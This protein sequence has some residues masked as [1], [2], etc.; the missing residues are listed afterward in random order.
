MLVTIALPG[1]YGN[2]WLYAAC[3][4]KMERALT[5]SATLEEACALLTLQ[6]AGAKRM[7]SLAGLNVVL[8]LMVAAMVLSWPKHGALPLH[9]GPIGQAQVAGLV[10]SGLATQSLSPPTTVPAAAPAPAPTLTASAPLAAA[11]LEA[12]APQ[13]AANVVA[14]SQGSAQRSSQGMVQEVAMAKPAPV[15]EIA[16]STPA[17]AAENA[18]QTVKKT[19]VAKPT[20][21][22]RLA[23]AKAAKVAARELAREAAKSRTGVA[24]KVTTAASSEPESGKFL[25][26]VGLFAD[27]NNARNAY[28]KLKDAGLPALSQ[29]VK[30]SKGPRTRVRV[31]PFESQPEADRAAERIRALQLDA[32]VFKQ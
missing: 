17:H 20:K 5:A 23:K 30:S 2:A 12:S 16:Q 32:A 29:A 11:S 21:A 31:G 28:V 26:N 27:A 10:Q 25:I 7:A 1:T 8:C 3:N 24:A 15:P 6:A 4:R 9:A 18:P 13:P 19:Q 22:E 14:L